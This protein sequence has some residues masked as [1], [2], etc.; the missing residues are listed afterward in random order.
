MPRTRSQAKRKLAQEAT[1]EGQSSFGSKDVR[2]ASPTREEEEVVEGEEQGNELLHEDV[3]KEDEEE[4]DDKEDIGSD[5]G[6]DSSDDEIKDEEDSDSKDVKEEFEEHKDGYEADDGDMEDDDDDDDE[7]NEEEEEEDDDDEEEDGDM[8]EAGDLAR[9]EQERGILSNKSAKGMADVMAG[10]LGMGTGQEVD[11]PILAKDKS[12]LR[13]I[14]E[15]QEEERLT[16]QEVKAKRAKID[17]TRQKPNKYDLNHERLLKKMATKGGMH[18]ILVPLCAAH[19]HI[20]HTS[21]H[22][23]VL[24]VLPSFA[25]V[26]V[27]L[28]PVAWWCSSPLAAVALFNAVREHQKTL[29]QGMREHALESVWSL[30][31]SCSPTHW[32]FPLAPWPAPMTDASCEFTLCFLS[33]RHW[34]AEEGADASKCQQNRVLGHALQQ[35]PNLT[36]A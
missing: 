8:L 25:F 22:P 2:A 1:E 31:L 26:L 9:E 17:V 6:Q 4:E 19:T 24:V 30:M 23:L 20:K 11:V 21:A 33:A 13:K 36:A 29:S 3:I 10:I 15:Q 12:T 14:V 18:A 28:L 7:D 16:M 35:D 34:V 32:L 5:D 27:H